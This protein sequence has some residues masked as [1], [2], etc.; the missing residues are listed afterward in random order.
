MCSLKKIELEIGVSWGTDVENSLFWE[1]L[2]LV[3]LEQNWAMVNGM[4]KWL[5]ES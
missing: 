5:I 1:K 3:D 4:K 2:V